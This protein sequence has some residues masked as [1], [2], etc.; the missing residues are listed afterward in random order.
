VVAIRVAEHAEALGQDALLLGEHVDA[1]TLA[2]AVTPTVG[3]RRVAADLSIYLQADRM[4]MVS[5]TPADGAELR[6][7]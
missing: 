2:V 6:Q 3:L 1:G 5:Y 4:L 7:V